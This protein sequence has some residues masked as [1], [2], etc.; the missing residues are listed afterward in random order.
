ITSSFSVP[1][2][3]LL[4]KKYPSEW[5]NLF[6][7]FSGLFAF[8][9]PLNR[10]PPK[11]G[12]GLSTQGVRVQNNMTVAAGI[13]YNPLSYWFISVTFYRYL[14]PQY[15]APWN[16]D[17]SYVFGYDDWHPFTFSLTYAN[18]GG[19]RLFP[20]K[21][22]GEVFTHFEEG[23]FSLG[24]KFVLP[25]AIERLFT[26]HETGGIGA[27]LAFNLTPK[28]MDLATLSRKSWKKTVSLGIKY[29][30]YKWWYANITLFYYPDPAQQ[31]PWDPDFTYGFG[32]FDWHPGT[33]TV[34]YNNYS[35]NR[36]PWRKPGPGTGRFKHGSITVSWSWA[37]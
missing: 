18:Y 29:T 9:Y 34:Q 13:K 15:Q 4:K 20:D 11:G 7:G 28:Y 12:I 22:E 14:N 23:T 3:D 26:V 8:D 5:R 1:L 27:N 10:V 31:Q 21:Q 24:W 17:F 32:Y 19:N 16:P 25:P 35:G 36:F 33:I 2:R 6:V 30:I 37:L